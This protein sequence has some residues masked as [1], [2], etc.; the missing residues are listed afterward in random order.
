VNFNG[1]EEFGYS[2][3]VWLVERGVTLKGGL[4]QKM[5]VPPALR[6]RARMTC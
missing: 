3:Q 2:V 6:A 1:D 4:L 5:L